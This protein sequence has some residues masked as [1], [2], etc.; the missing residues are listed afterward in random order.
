[1]YREADQEEA[2]EDNAY[3]VKYGRPASHSKKLLAACSSRHKAPAQIFFLTDANW[4]QIKKSMITKEKE[5]KMPIINL[6]LKEFVL[7]HK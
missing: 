4:P 5:K 6:L 7:L 1:M 2:S 3:T